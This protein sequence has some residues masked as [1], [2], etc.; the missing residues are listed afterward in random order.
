[1]SS[2]TDAT[3]IFGNPWSILDKEKIN[4][5]G[6]KEIKDTEERRKCDTKTKAAKLTSSIHVLQPSVEDKKDGYIR[7]EGYIARSSFKPASS[8][9]HFGASKPLT[10]PS[11]SAGSSSSPR[12]NPFP[13]FP[14]NSQTRN[15]HNHLATIVP[16]HDEKS[17]PNS[18]ATQ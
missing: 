4:D 1:M 17:D 16:D 14:P 15:T 9:F 13:V 6:F 3:R 18:C 2:D 8:T 7:G 12:S 10:S 11:V 5:Q